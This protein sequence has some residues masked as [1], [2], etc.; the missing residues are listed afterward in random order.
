MK[1]RFLADENIDPDLVL[2]LRRQD[3]DVDIVRVQDVGLR[4]A[5]DPVILQWAADH[6]RIL[7]SHDRRTIPAFAAE[8]L[9]AGLAMPGVI[10]LR[11]TLPLTDAIQQLAVV[12]GASDAAEWVDQIAYLPLR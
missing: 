9:A 4:T 10:L 1:P 7:I 12:A 8:R 5:E 11:S 2:G 6:G 3:D